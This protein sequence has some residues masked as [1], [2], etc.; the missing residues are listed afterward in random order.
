VEHWTSVKNIPKYLNRTKEMFLVYGGDEE[1]VVKGYI[2]A[3]FDTDPDDSKSLIGYVYILNGGAVSWRSCKQSVIVGS[4]TKAEY[5]AASEVLSE[6]VWMRNFITDLG[7][8][9]SALDPLEILCDNTGAI[10]L[11]KEPRYHPMTKH[12]NRRFH[13][14]RDY[15]LDGDLKISKVHMDLNVANS[16]A[17]PLPRAKHDQHLNAMGVRLLPDIN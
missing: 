11:A 13:I 7:V 17:K 9:P 15:I 3:S 6:G 14:I 4:T 12:I 8:V 1:L 2:D 5:M 10:A 16:L